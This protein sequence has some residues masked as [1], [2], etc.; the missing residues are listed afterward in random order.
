[1]RVIAVEVAKMP[2]GYF[3]VIIWGQH[4]EHIMD[5]RGCNYRYLVVKKQPRKGFQ[6]PKAA[7]DWWNHLSWE[8]WQSELDRALE[9]N[10][11]HLPDFHGPELTLTL[12]RLKKS[13]AASPQAR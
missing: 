12:D 11:S 6:T 13:P 2:Q 8:Y 7:E 9:T 4:D 10:G 3:K 5:W 1:M